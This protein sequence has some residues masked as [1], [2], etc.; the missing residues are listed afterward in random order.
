MNWIELKQSSRTW[1][2]NACYR[3]TNT[4]CWQRWS[5]CSERIIWRNGGGGRGERCDM[6][7]YTEGGGKKTNNGAKKPENEQSQIYVNQTKW[8]KKTTTRNT[9]KKQQQK[10]ETS[11][12]ELR[13]PTLHTFEVWHAKRTEFHHRLFAK[14]AA[15]APTKP[16]K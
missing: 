14:I 15:T 16:A 10:S 12:N 7:V 1:F 5:W 13:C 3:L 11:Q 2:F 9:Q 4:E 8:A 6:D